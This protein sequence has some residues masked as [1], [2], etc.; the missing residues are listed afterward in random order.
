MDAVVAFLSAVTKFIFDQFDITWALY[1]GGGVFGFSLVL[2]ILD[3]LL[4]IFDVMK[5]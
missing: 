2:W 4:H 1:T 3:R 5:R